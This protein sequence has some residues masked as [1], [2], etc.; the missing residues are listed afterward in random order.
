MTILRLEQVSKS[1]GSGKPVL[2]DL[3]LAVEEGELLTILGAS[4]SGK[5]TLL[6]ILNALIPF[7]AGWVEV[8]GKLLSQ[9]DPVTLR[10]EMGYVI[11]NVG[12]FPHLTVEGNIGYVLSL[13]GWKKEAMA[14]RVRELLALTGLSRHLLGRYP[15]EL[16]GG[17]KQRVGVARALAARPGILLMDEPFG[18]VD[19]L[20][21]LQLQKELIQIHR[22]LGVTILLVTHDIGE[23]LRL[24][25]R[26]LLLQEGRVAQLGTP[27]ELL[28]QP[29]SQYVREF[30]G[31][32]GLFSALSP[33][34]MEEVYSQLLEQGGSMEDFH[35]LLACERLNKE[36]EGR[37]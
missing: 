1:Y 4:G 25:T 32:R 30:L 18:A 31:G 27:E 9:W 21:R 29:A 23:A 8:K 20:T 2:L 10:R 12:L 7:E 35:R 28:F 17:Q 26:V 24:G 6:R 15:R 16:S 22:E 36:K 37:S 34:E 3:N 33:Q 19:E 5:S 11:Q 13:M 14:E